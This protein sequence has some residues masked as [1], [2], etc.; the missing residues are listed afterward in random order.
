M[1]FCDVYTTIF[2]FVVELQY[3]VKLAN[4]RKTV[5]LNISTIYISLAYCN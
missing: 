3:G 4:T 1:V 2:I 5:R